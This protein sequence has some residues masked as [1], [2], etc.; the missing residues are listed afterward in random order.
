MLI[1]EQFMQADTSS[2]EQFAKTFRINAPEDFN[3]GFDVLDALAEKSP[4]KLA[5]LYT[6]PKGCE[7]RFSFSAMRAYSNRAANY[8][9]S[10]GIRKGDR[11]MLILKRNYQYWFASMGLCKLGAVLIPATIQLCAK[12]IAYRCNAAGVKMIVCA[13]DMDTIQ[14]VE[15]AIPAS[16]TVLHTSLVGEPRRGWLDFDAGLHAQ[17]DTFA[18]PTGEQKPYAH[19]PMLIYFT[20]GTTGHPKMALHNFLYPLGHIVTARFWHATDENGLHFTISDTGWAKAA[21]GKLYGQWLSECAVFVCDF[22]R[23]SAPD[24]LEVLERY[25]ITTFCAPPTMYRMLTQENIAAYDLSAL[26]QCCSAGEAL[27][28]EVFANWKDAT[29]LCIREGFGQSET[30]CCLGTLPNMPIKIG[31]M[32]RP[33]PGYTIALLDKKGHPCK[34]GACGEICIALKD[35]QSAG[36]FLGYYRNEARTQEVWHDGYYHTG[37]TAY[38]DDDG[39]FWYVGRADD[40]IKSSGY[41]IGPF[42]VESVLMTHPAVLE[43]AVTGVPDAVRGQVVKAT[44]VLKQGYEGTDILKRELQNHVKT[45]TAPYK[46]PR[47]IHFVDALPKTVSGKIKRA[48]IRRAN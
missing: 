43:A 14:A 30:T 23:F 47:V 37:D 17:P 1:Y 41:R 3:Y 35:V 5:L 39:Y 22:D 38:M 26:R 31:S 10:L 44:I 16:P 9:Y 34:G 11:V 46:Y 18:R 7:L 45:Q 6:N 15:A 28:P 33:M 24:I 36:L 40:I 29:G 27:T 13:E 25:H 19:D 12:D 48:E 4:E 42:E 32:G 8:F 2:Y 20:S 21:W